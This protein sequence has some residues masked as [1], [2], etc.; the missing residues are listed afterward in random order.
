MGANDRWMPIVARDSGPARVDRNAR[1]WSAAPPVL[2]LTRS[3]NTPGSNPQADGSPVLVQVRENPLG[4]SGGK[5]GNR[6]QFGDR[7]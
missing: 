7:S 1:R 6:R 4:E 3:P 2:E 5:A